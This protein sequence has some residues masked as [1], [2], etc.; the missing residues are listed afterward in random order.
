M[1]GLIYQDKQ[2]VLFFFRRYWQVPWRHAKNSPQKKK[3]KRMTE[4]TKKK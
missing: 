2:L 1:Y 4:C 3:R